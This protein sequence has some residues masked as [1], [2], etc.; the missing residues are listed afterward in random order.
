MTLLVCGSKSSKLANVSGGGSVT[1]S[2]KTYAAAASSG[3]SSPSIS[4]AQLLAMLTSNNQS[5]KHGPQVYTVIFN[6]DSRIKVK[7]N[8]RIQKFKKCHT[9]QDRFKFVKIQTTPS[10]TVGR[11]TLVDFSN[12]SGPLAPPPQPFPSTTSPAISMTATQHKL[13]T[14]NATPAAET[15]AAESRYYSPHQL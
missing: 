6:S 15:P 9:L 5:P 1:K 3:A 8:K 4:E 14:A 10:K 2:G 12:R 11:W 13:K 7:Y